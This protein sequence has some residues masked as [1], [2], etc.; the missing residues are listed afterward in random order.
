MRSAPADVP[1][2]VAVPRVLT[3]SL[4]PA[5]LALVLTACGDG[6]GERGTGEPTGPVVPTA[7]GN[8]TNSTSP[9]TGTMAAAPTGPACS[10]ERCYE[11]AGIVGELAP[12][13]VEAASGMA[14]S[15]R[16][17]GL[18]YVV[19]DASGTSRVAVVEGDGTLVAHLEIEGMSARNAEALAIGPCGAA[20]SGNS[21]LF[22]GD[23]GNHVGL[24]D[25]VVYRAVEPDLSDPPDT[26][27]ADQLRY[28]YPDAPTDAEALLVDGEG[29]PLVI[30]KAPFDRDTG[31]TGA[32]VLFRG[33]HDG[34]ALEPLGEIDLPEPERP[35]FAPLVGHVVTGADSAEGRV[36]L[37][38]YDEV[39]EYRS[40]QPDADPADFPE[41]PRRRVPSPSQVQAEAV[42]YRADGCGYLTTSE[43]TGSI[44][45]VN[46]R[47]SP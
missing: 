24:P 34:G 42:A 1:Y 23:I 30:S 22:V 20:G 37:R 10:G 18:F 40:D 6:A 14:A 36:L 47:E 29:R 41:W 16:T 21:C 7:T 26:V 9:G 2:R 5:A 19:S 11:D 28:T 31:T 17:P 13:V 15:R 12:D 33:S 32:T 43:L 8:P 3:A 46:C 38:T 44:V 25:L 4:A 35:A 27:A 39:Y 45:A